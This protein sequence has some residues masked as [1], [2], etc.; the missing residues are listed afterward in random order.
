VAS[1]VNETREMDAGAVEERIEQLCRSF[2]AQKAYLVEL[3]SGE[4]KEA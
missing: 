2:S 4:R 1:F 3:W